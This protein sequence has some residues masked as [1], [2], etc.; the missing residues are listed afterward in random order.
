MRLLIY[1][2]ALRRIETKLAPFGD[3]LQ[4]LVI[5]RQGGVTCGDQTLR[6][7]RPSPTPVGCRPTRSW[8]R[9]RAP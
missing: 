5:D 9:R 2:T 8:A 4:L 3:Q 7:T 6:P 1:E